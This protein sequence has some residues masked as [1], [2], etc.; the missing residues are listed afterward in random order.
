M[1]TRKTL[2]FA[3]LTL[4]GALLAGCGEDEPA[5]EESTQVQSET[6]TEADVQTSDGNDMALE[7][8]DS[9]QAMPENP[10]ANNE[11]NKDAPNPP[12]IESGTNIN[13]GT[14]NDNMPEPA[15]DER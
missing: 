2:L 10:A 12:D 5:P 13:T 11:H 14:G 15:S 3:T 9:E 6:A 4:A 7:P 1:E 8:Q